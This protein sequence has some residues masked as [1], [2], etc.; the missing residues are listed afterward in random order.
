MFQP[1]IG[2]SHV[3][4]TRLLPAAIAPVSKMPASSETLQKGDGIPQ[5]EN[6]KS[7]NITISP[8]QKE[9]LY[10]I[11][12]GD[13]S[14]ASENGGRTY[15]LRLVQS[16]NHKDY[17][18][19]LVFNFEGF[20]KTPPKL[21]L[22]NNTYYWNSLQSGSFRF[23]GHEFY[24]QI[25]E[26]KFEKKVPANVARWLTPRAATYWF[27]DDGSAKDKKTTT[28]IRFCTDSFSHSDVERLAE[29]LEQNFDVKT[30]IYENRP[31]QYR[32]YCKAPSVSSFWDKV[33]PVLQNEIAGTAPEILTKLPDKIS[34]QLVFPSNYSGNRNLPLD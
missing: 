23:Y 1:N 2:L 24:N 26:N 31:N 34:N 29:G 4:S 15:R 8:Y 12:L 3:E 17:F 28:A 7:K 22:A 25:D 11:L 20:G 19:H 6:L 18:D 14:L 21:N 10:G 30:S 9:I 32:I 16:K 27:L 33:M 13:A 5:L